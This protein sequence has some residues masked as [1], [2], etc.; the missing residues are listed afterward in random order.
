MSF[1]DVPIVRWQ[2]VDELRDRLVAWERLN[3]PHT[4]TPLNPT[5]T[6]NGN[7]NGG[8]RGQRLYRRSKE[9]RKALKASLARCLV[10]TRRQS[11]RAVSQLTIQLRILESH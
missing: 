2:A 11:Q 4:P 8:G 6:G 5:A 10:A 1:I 3:N 9:G 7:G